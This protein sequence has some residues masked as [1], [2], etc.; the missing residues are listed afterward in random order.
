MCRLHYTLV[1]MWQ[2]PY[3]TKMKMWQY[4]WA[5]TAELSL[6]EC[7]PWYV[8]KQ[9]DPNVPACTM[10]C[11]ACFVGMHDDAVTVHTMMQCSACGMVSRHE[12]GHVHIACNHFHITRCWLQHKSQHTPRQA[13]QLSFVPVAHILTSPNCIMMILAH[14]GLLLSAFVHADLVPDPHEVPADTELHEAASSDCDHCSG[15]QCW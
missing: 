8:G 15:C 9:I 7:G 1:N 14:D 4:W 12:H 10:S 2:A 6:P 3:S 13:H 5:R 11:T